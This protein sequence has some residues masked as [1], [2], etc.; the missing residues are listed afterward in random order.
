MV[1][2]LWEDPPG[3]QEKLEEVGAE[4]CLVAPSVPLLASLAKRPREYMRE[5][6]YIWQPMEFMGDVDALKV[7]QNDGRRESI[8]L[9]VGLPAPGLRPALTVRR[10]QTK[11]RGGLVQCIDKKRRTRMR[12]RTQRG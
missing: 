8:D 9:L 2:G 7:T 10:G 6:Y 5:F 12:V 1:T 4:W 11:A 3:W